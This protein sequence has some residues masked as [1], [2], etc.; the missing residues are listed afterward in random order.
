MVTDLGCGN[1][2][3]LITYPI[4][5]S[6]GSSVGQ[7]KGL[8]ILVSVVQ[9][10]LWTYPFGILNSVDKTINILKIDRIIDVYYHNLMLLYSILT[11]FVDN[12]Q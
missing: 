9:I 8:K 12:I 4:N 7:S 10:H 2:I 6:L 11:L 5:F 3:E 1:L